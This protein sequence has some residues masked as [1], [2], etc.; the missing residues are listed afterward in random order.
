MASDRSASLKEVHRHVNAAWLILSASTWLWCGEYIGG[1]KEDP[2]TDSERRAA[3]QIV[4]Q[5]GR[6]AGRETGRQADRQ[7]FL[8]DTCSK[9][10]GGSALTG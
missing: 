5:S 10:E 1:T 8:E 7:R 2:Q 6:Q 3:R 9:P 4:S